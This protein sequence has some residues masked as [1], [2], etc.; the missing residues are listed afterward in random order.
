MLK[1][2][3]QGQ[4]LH[5]SSNQS[6][7][8]GNAGSLTHWG[9]RELQQLFFFFFFFFFLAT[10]QHMEILGQGSNLSHSCDIQSSCSNTGSL[11]YCPASGIKPTY[12]CF[13]DATNPIPSYY[14][15]NSEN[16]SSCSCFLFSL[17]CL[18]EKVSSI[19]YFFTILIPDGIRTFEFSMVA[20]HKIS[21]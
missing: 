4:N 2:S 12:Q 10:P 11:S 15:R 1:F 8:S 3:S 20:W 19:F 9:I 16:C 13:R 21:R 17:I 5:H 7:S 6:H 14:S 18:W